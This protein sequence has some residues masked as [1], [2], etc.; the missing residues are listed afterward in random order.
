[1]IAGLGQASKLV[2][3]NIIQQAHG[4]SPRLPG[5]KVKGQA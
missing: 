4:K 1:M 3:E 2:T 5:G